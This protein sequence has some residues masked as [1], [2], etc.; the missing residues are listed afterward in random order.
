[1]SEY[2]NIK[3][4]EGNVII[5]D[6]F[7]NLKL[8]RKISLYNLT[9]AKPSGCDNCATDNS[10]YE[11]YNR[12]FRYFTLNSDEFCFGVTCSLA[13]MHSVNFGIKK[14]NSGNIFAFA[15]SGNA[16]QISIYTFTNSA[17][18]D[19]GNTGLNIFNSSGKQ[20]FN[21][22]CRYLNVLS[23]NT[24]PGLVDEPEKILIPTVLNAPSCL[25][26]HKRERVTIDYTVMINAQGTP[27]IFAKCHPYHMYGFDPGK[28]TFPCN[29]I[30]GSV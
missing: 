21:S 12:E 28:T 7:I 13:T 29:Y 26:S 16:S 23:M 18:N 6:S 5:N 3:N 2:I 8:S 19:S 30:I 20:I 1:M 17:P 10:E 15:Y 4:R 11:E 9:S 14:A 27:Y 22:N 24:S 25:E